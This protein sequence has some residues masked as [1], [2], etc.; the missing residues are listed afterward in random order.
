MSCKSEEV[1][2]RAKIESLDKLNAL[3]QQIV[4]LSEEVVPLYDDIENYFFQEVDYQVLKSVI[5]Q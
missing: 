5:C 1:I 3:Y 4:D 2:E